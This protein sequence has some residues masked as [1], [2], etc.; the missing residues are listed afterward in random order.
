MNLFLHDAQYKKKTC[1]KKKKHSYITIL[2][3]LELKKA[4]NV[5]AQHT[6]LIR[7]FYLDGYRMMF[8]NDN[9]MFIKKNLFR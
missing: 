9:L 5:W 3:R 2:P 8:E 7:V 1:T 6:F 4:A